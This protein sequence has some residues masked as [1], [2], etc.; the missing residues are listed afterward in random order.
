[1][2]TLILSLTDTVK[3][4]VTVEKT[5]SRKS[6]ETVIFVNARV[7]LPDIKGTAFNVD[8]IS[9]SVRKKKNVF[10]IQ[11]QSGSMEYVLPAGVMKCTISSIEPAT[12]GRIIS[13]TIMEAVSRAHLLCFMTRE[14][15]SVTASSTFI[16]PE[17]DVFSVRSRHK[18]L[19]ALR[20]I[21]NFN[22]EISDV[23]KNIVCLFVF[24]N[25]IY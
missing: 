10:A 24:Q 3:G 11:K 13:G 6:L 8:L 5:R 7:G 9:G 18:T 21:T 22:R 2:N 1:M 12:A 20:F 14:R 25:R 19:I 17:T 16:D 23:V 15:D 4:K